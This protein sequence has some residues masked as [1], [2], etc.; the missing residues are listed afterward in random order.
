KVCS[1]LAILVLPFLLWGRIDDP[2]MKTATTSTTTP[3]FTWAGLGTAMLGVQWAYHGWMNIAPVAEEVQ[4][5][6]RN[7]PLALLGGVCSFNLLYLGANVDYHLVIPQTEMR[8]LKSTTVATE[9]CL[10]LLGS[11]GAVVA[12]GAVMCSVFGALNGNLLVGPRL[13]YAMGQDRLAP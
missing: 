1:L 2:V 8:D 10:R 9:F 3:L 11:I 12:S 6:Q 13:L 5:P 7:I 4:R